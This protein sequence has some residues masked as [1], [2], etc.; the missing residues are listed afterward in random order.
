ME[1]EK[2]GLSSELARS[3]V[4]GMATS[5][6]GLL[7]GAGFSAGAIGG[8]KEPLPSAWKLSEDLDKEYALGAEPEEYARLP[9]IY[10]DA[11]HSPKGRGNVLA[12]MRRRFTG[13]VPDWQGA[14]LDFDW[15]RIW[16]LNIDDLLD[17]ASREER[18]WKVDP[19]SHVD[20]LRAPDPRSGEV[21][22][23]HLHGRAS[24]ISGEKSDLVFSLPEYSL[25]TK[26]R[27]DWLSE[28]W[29]VWLQRPFVVI[30]AKLLEELD[31]A[32][33]LGRGTQ[34]L[35]TTGF[36]TVVVLRDVSAREVQRLERKGVFVIRG[37]GKEFI[38]ALKLDLDAYFAAR[39]G[40]AAGLSASQIAAF[41]AQFEL[42]DGVKFKSAIHDFHAG[43]E[44]RWADIVE[45]KDAAFSATKRCAKFLAS[46]SQLP[47]VALISGRPGGGKSAALLRIA[48][49]ELARARAVAFFRGERQLDVEAALAWL[50]VRPKAT[51]LFDNG[52]DHSESVGELVL[53]VRSLALDVNIVVAE[54]SARASAVLSDI[55]AG[56]SDV[57]VFEFG[58]IKKDDVRSLVAVRERFARLGIGTSWTSE[59]WES[60]FMNR[61]RGDLFSALSEIEGGTGFYGRMD[62]EVRKLAPKSNLSE[63]RLLLA[64]AVVHR[65]GYS[66]PIRTAQQVMSAVGGHSMND[67]FG[68]ALLPLVE[69]DKKGVRLRHRM[70]AER[71]I[72]N[73]SDVDDRYSVSMAIAQSLGALLTRQSM[74]GKSYNYLILRA[75]MDQEHVLS[76]LENIS[77]AR[78]WYE[79]LEDL[80]S[81]NGRYWDQRALLESGGD[82]HDRAYSYAKRSVDLHRHPFSLTTLG[83]VR[84][85]AA[86]D[87]ARIDMGR[88]WEFF[89]EGNAALL[90]SEA[91]ARSRGIAYEHPFVTFYSAA[92]ELLEIMPPEDPRRG[93]LDN[94]KGEWDRLARE[95]VNKPK[96]VRIVEIK[97]REWDKKILRAG[98]VRGMENR[99]R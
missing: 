52:A 50:K 65:S 7:L 85:R 39:P 10:E 62:V 87:V 49:E 30:G 75:L 84:C 93:R 33:A 51:L 58:L 2:F 91:L 69:F 76:L 54:R 12:Y 70:L 35:K 21:Q 63:L 68:E 24:N 13:C 61:H 25:T 60:H 22:V 78:R 28:F 64:T 14:V 96:L 57:S 97:T 88:G 15:S 32:G 48:A 8:D 26:G 23:V 27:G 40:L 6:Y 67:L 94:L 44:P 38:G 72:R 41:N 71:F 19:H 4:E 1:L 43:D 47:R 29:S 16:T 99:Q 31:L 81:W 90:E 46:L 36:P 9:Q 17:V 5:E 42:L 77:L 95:V 80:F 45:S 11:L 86:L 66:L 20:N 89:T 79:D 92:L 55:G 53:K 3:L 56:S 82:F 59:E 73:F 98:V 34:A 74:G 37:T 18:K 83:A